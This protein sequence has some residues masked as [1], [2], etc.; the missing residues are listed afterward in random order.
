MRKSEP[1]KPFLPSL[2]VVMVFY[3]SNSNSNEETGLLPYQVIYQKVSKKFQIS[4]TQC[5]LDSL[6]AVALENPRGLD[7]LT[8]APG[9][10]YTLS[11]E[12]C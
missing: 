5:K 3:H 6:L 7:F 10:T 12:Q 1:N 9:D 8:L 2:L 4:S 11:Q